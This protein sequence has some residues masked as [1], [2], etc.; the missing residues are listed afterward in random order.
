MVFQVPP[1]QIETKNHN[2]YFVR[3]FAIQTVENI[4]TIHHSLYPR[5]EKK[6]EKLNY[7]KKSTC[8]SVK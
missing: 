7:K 4:E 6:N 3:V 8:I 1:N 2:I 5:E